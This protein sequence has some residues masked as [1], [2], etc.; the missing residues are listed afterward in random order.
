MLSVLQGSC[1]GINFFLAFYIATSL[2]FLWRTKQT[3]E[4]ESIGICPEQKP[5]PMNCN[6]ED[7]ISE[8]IGIDSISLCNIGVGSMNP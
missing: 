1:D 8:G 5:E 3:L 2:K 6:E 7:H 4:F